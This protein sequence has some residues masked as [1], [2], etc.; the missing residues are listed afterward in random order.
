MK[1]INNLDRWIEQENSE[2]QQQKRIET[3]P[4]PPPVAATRPLVVGRH[5]GSDAT[6]TQR[7]PPAAAAEL[8]QSATAAAETFVPRKHVQENHALWRLFSGPQRY[9]TVQKSL[10][11]LRPFRFYKSWSAVA[12]L[13]RSPHTNSTRLLHL[14][15]FKYTIIK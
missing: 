13:A 4:T 15:T 7:L 11:S 8:R 12:R 14:L 3:A 1:L 6:A 9:S 2:Q 5:F 10:S